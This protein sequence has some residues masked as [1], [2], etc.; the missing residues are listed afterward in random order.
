MF[1]HLQGLLFAF[2]SPNIPSM[3]FMK[4]Q[5]EREARK[6]EAN[7]YL[8]SGGMHPPAFRLSQRLL[9]WPN[10][11]IE[12]RCGACGSTVLS[13][14]KLLAERHGNQTFAEVLG[15]IKCRRCGI[16]PESVFLCAGNRTQHGGPPP[17]WAIELRG[18]PQ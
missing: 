14:T 6:A 1:T 17:D 10:C 7:G 9:D 16:P 4:R 13:P 18:S 2:S 8:P 3:G 12:M 11:R 5:A 15:R